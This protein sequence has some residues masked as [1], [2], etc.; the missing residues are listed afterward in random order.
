MKWMKY[1]IT[2]SRL[3][4]DDIELVRRWRNKRHI[5]ETMLYKKY[6]SKDQ[7]KK[8]FASVNNN[9]NSYYLIIYK[10]KKIGLINNKNIKSDDSSSEAGIFVWND[11]YDF[12]PLIASLLLCEIG[13]YVLKGGDSHIKVLST[14]QRALDY[15]T[16][17]GYEVLEDDAAQKLSDSENKWDENNPQHIFHDPEKEIDEKN[18]PPSIIKL[19][20]TKEM[21]RVNTEKIRKTVHV[22]THSDGRLYLVLEKH[23]FESELAQMMENLYVFPMMAE[24]PG[25]IDC[26]EENGCKTY[27][28]ILI[29]YYV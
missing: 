27:S 2:L 21:F 4:E 13:F 3:T 11:H 15:N 7:Q 17:L 14:N 25:T 20:L 28:G 26:I 5:R 12:V 24:V 8:W 18:P 22:S 29:I 16:I 19:K 9:N 6:I 10:N 1:G 23:D